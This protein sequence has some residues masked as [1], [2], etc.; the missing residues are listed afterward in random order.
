MTTPPA[1]GRKIVES[2][3]TKTTIAVH[4]AAGATGP[5]AGGLGT[6]CHAR[7]LA[8]AIV[9]ILLV[10]PRGTAQTAPT[11]QNNPPKQT[12]PKSGGQVI[13]SRSTDENGATT[14]QVG[15]GAKPVL[16][17]ASEPSVEDADRLAVTFTNLDLDVRLET[18]EHQIAVRARV[19]VRNDGKAPSL[20]FLYRFPHRST[21]SR[22]GF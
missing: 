12:A 9:A 17:I 13:F 14:T 20:A 7:T 2:R 4:D 1:F 15:P 3:A 5:T 8:A 21:G 22:F 18:A 16:P 19:T 6:L 10:V 11:P